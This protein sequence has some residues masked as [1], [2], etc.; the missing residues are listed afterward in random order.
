MFRQDR[1]WRIELKHH[2]MSV[3]GVHWLDGFRQ[4]IDRSATRGPS[5]AATIRAMG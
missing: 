4:L 5:S 3:M 2:A 1:G